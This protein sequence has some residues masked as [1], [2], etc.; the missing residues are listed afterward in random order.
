M[1]KD[2]TSRACS[3]GI[4]GIQVEIYSYILVSFLYVL[5]HLR[6]SAVA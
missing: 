2:T 3:D 1:Q 5:T 4:D 6:G